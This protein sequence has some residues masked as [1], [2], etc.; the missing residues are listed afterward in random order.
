V[1]LT[2]QPLLNQ[3]PPVETQLVCLDRDWF[4]IAQQ[5][6]TNPVGAATADNLAYVIYTSGTTG[7]PKGVQISHA[8]LLNFLASMR[9]QPGLNSQD[10]LLAVTTLSFDIAGLE[11][12]LLPS[13]GAVSSWSS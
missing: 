7:K 11:L 9:Q 4:L 13:V 1:L 8:A 3:L 10:T 5:P 2:Q 12:F 6:Q